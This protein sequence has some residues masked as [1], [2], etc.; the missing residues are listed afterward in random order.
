MEHE[1]VLKFQHYHATHGVHQTLF[2]SETW[3][4]AED[5]LGALEVG[6]LR[7]YS[8]RM[9]PSSLAAVFC[10]DCALERFDGEGVTS[11]SIPYRFQP[12]GLLVCRKEI[13]IFELR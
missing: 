13:R 4:C 12:T 2:C 11:G 8:E 5:H 10:P 7:E 3:P 6:I 9:L 1:R